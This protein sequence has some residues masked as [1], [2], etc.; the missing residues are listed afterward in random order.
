[1]LAAL[2][3][4]SGCS[5]DDKAKHGAGAAGS[6][7]GGSSL[8]P[9]DCAKDAVQCEGSVAKVCDGKGG[10]SSSQ[11]CAKKNQACVSSH[12]DND[13]TLI[14]LGC[15]ACVPGVASCKDG[16]ASLCRADGSGIDAFDCDPMQ[17]M[18]CEADGCKGVCAPPEVTTSYIGCDY[19][20]TVTLNPV[21][22]GFD[23]AVAVSNASDAP[24][25]VV[26]T[27]GDALIRELTID[28]NKLEI[29][30][31]DWVAALKGGDQDACQVPPEPGDSRLVKQGAYRLRSNHPVTVYQLSPLE[32]QLGKAGDIPSGCPVGT[33]CPGGIV[34]DCLS[35][36]NDAALLLPATT[37]S[38]DYTVMSW[39]SHGN[40][41]SFFAVTATADTTRVTLDGRAS[42]RPGGGVDRNG[43]GTVMLNRGDV[44]EV[45]AAHGDHSD[46]ASGS[47]VHADKPVQVIGGHSCAN[48]PDPDTAACDHLEQ[49]LFPT[50]ILGKDYVVSYP[51]AVASQSPHIVR[52]AAVQANTTIHFEPAM[53]APITLGPDSPPVEFQ[54][55]GYTPGPP[56]ERGTEQKP[57]DVRVTADKPI[58]IVQ[59][60]QGQ[61]SVPSGAGDPSMA[62]VVPVAQYRSDYTFTASTT[63]DSNFINV[64]APIGTTVMLDGKPLEGDAT[65]VGTTD[66]HV[67]RAQLP[68]DGS[69]VYR[70][71][72]DAPFGLVVYGYGRYTSYMYPGGLDLKR[73]TVVVPQ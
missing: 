1:M 36:S 12:Y 71:Q 6:G 45:V 9:L 5:C 60:M 27:R 15:V 26:V 65:D 16:K 14:P 21:W 48:I 68:G 42:F 47:L 31:L 29:I 28:V 66:Y 22:S 40:T 43:A 70:I 2:L 58:S 54:V 63:Y 41:A 23:F 49:A 39:P 57:V 8:V 13:G 64:I 19:Y 55:G 56:G 4:V 20:P 3:S 7:D 67:I 25:H 30:K 37:L 38:G 17:G 69:G 18:T 46:D 53:M 35:Y 51:A 11:D 10:F 32:Y 50:Q 59:Y 24:A 73:I 61:A 62:L 33:A 72:A 52:I 34:P 44:L